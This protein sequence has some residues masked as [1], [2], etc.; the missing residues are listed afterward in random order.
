H[1]LKSDGH[2]AYICPHKFFNAQYG[3]PIR[4]VI[5]KGKHLRHV[6]HFGDAQVFPGATIYSCLLFLSSG[7]SEN[8]R[9]VKAHDLGGWKASGSAV[10][11]KIP[12]TAIK[13]GEW[14]FTVGKG[15]GLFDLLNTARTKLGD[16]ADSFVGLQTSA[17]DVYIL[18]LVEERHGSLVCYSKSLDKEVELERALLHP[19]VSGTDVKGFL[20]L[21][22][23]QFILFPYRVQDSRATLIPF[24][25]IKAHHKLTADYLTKNRERLERRAN[26]RF[27]DTDWY[28]FGRSQNLG[29]QETHKLCVPRLVDHL[30][31]GIDLEGTHYLDNVDVG[32]VTWKPA[33]SKRSL[34]TLCALL[35]SQVLRWFFPHVSAPFRGGFRSANRQF[36]AP[37]SSLRCIPESG[38]AG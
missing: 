27:A 22:S 3:E 25:T 33:Y 4:E 31:A 35:N 19:I 10:E 1:L 20:P 32:G 15:A 5:A 30:H 17:D 12:S 23:R 7:A 6:V 13:G 21:P 29:I 37:S 9:F 16:V 38:K 28:R 34:K 2:L 8:C 18:Q 24:S 36:L 26:G 14:N 11:G